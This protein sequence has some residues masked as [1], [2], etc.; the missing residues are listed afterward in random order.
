[1]ADQLLQTERATITK[2]L[3]SGFTYDELLRFL[4]EFHVINMNEPTLK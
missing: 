2:Y 3:N 4:S 1:M